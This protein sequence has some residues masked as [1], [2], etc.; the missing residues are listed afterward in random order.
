MNNRYTTKLIYSW[1]KK[2]GLFTVCIYV[3]V[4]KVR[5]TDQKSFC[6]VNVPKKEVSFDLN[7]KPT[8]YSF[9]CARISSPNN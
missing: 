7:N 3:T 4:Y 2:N 1:K 6:Y 5:D 9:I 8:R